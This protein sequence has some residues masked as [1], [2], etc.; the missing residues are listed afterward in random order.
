M[1]S[2]GFSTTTMNGGKLRKKIRVESNQNCLPIAIDWMNVLILIEW[3]SDRS[4]QWVPKKKMYSIFTVVNYNE[5]KVFLFLSL[6]YKSKPG[7]F[8]YSVTLN[9]IQFF[10][11]GQ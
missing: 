7:P 2:L 11:G 1:L 5:Y 4:S 6:Q 10:L 3:F 8:C 9:K